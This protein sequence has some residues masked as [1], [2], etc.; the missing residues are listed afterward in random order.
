M[1]STSDGFHGAAAA[2]RTRRQE[3]RRR[4]PP[5]AQLAATKMGMIR[6]TCQHGAA[7]AITVSPDPR[8]SKARA[9][10]RRRA[11]LGCGAPRG[12]RLSLS[13]FEALAGPEF[14]S[15]FAFG[16]CATRGAGRTPGAGSV[17]L[18]DPPF[19]FDRRRCGVGK[20][21][22]RNDPTS[23]TSSAA[24]PAV[25]N[26]LSG[27]GRIDSRPS[28]VAGA[29]IGTRPRVHCRMCARR[30]SRFIGKGPQQRR[31]CAGRRAR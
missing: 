5:A 1:G 13:M 9:R 22:M 8:S 29:E 25:L 24:V 30:G 16:E 18:L 27:R 20:C 21:S 7:G 4:G 28:G 2:M 15:S 12:L 17:G 19:G 6:L 26:P 3:A 23:R 14:H 31:C 11:V 10:Q